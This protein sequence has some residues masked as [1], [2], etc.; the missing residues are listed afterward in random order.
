METRPAKSATE[1][2][3]CKFSAIQS[4]SSCSARISEACETSETLRWGLSPGSPQEEHQL[5]CHRVRDGTATIFLHPRERE[6]NAGGDA[7]G[8]VDVPVF[9][10][11]WRG[12]HFNARI[13]LRKLASKAPMRSRPLAVQQSG[14]GEQGCTNTDRAEAA[15][16]RR[17]ALEPGEEGSVVCMASPQPTYEQRAT[18]WCCHIL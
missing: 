13:A 12:L 6:I 10:P 4:W 16:S 9:D 7:G 1:S 2:F 8:G 17:R 5:A 18:R 11:E 3:F 14:A 15:Q